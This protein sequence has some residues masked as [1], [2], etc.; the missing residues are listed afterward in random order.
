MKN[1][2]YTVWKNEKLFLTK[3]LF[4]KSTLSNLSN[5]SIAFLCQKSVRGNFCNYHTVLC[6]PNNGP[7]IKLPANEAIMHDN[8]AENGCLHAKSLEASF[9]TLKTHK[10]T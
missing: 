8:Q 1:E 7:Q 5:K 3:I 4:V 10:I 2:L 6:L 9:L